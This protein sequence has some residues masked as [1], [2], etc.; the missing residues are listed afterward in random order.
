MQLWKRIVTIMHMHHVYDMYEIVYVIRSC[1]FCP[2][3]TVL[4]Y[5][6]ALRGLSSAPLQLN[7]I[8]AF[9]GVDC[10]LALATARAGHA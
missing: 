7:C 6:K 2:D 3:L 9:A 8:A 5:G 10:K 4:M 1:P